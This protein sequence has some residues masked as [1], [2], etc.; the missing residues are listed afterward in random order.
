MTT[1]HHHPTPAERALAAPELAVVTLRVWGTCDGCARRI[2]PGDRISRRVGGYTICVRCAS[3]TE[4][5]T[6]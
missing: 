2:T 6:A 1:N 4:A 3:S 5:A